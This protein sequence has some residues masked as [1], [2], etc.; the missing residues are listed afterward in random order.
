[1]FVGESLGMTDAQDP[2]GRVVTQQPCHISDGSTDR[3]ETAWWRVDD[4]PAKGSDAA[5]LELGENQVK[6]PVGQECLARVQV[7]EHAVQERPRI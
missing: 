3:F 5:L 7:Q 6:V 1:V 4:E 2:Q